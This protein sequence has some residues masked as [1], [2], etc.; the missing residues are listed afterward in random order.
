MDRIKKMIL[1][2][3]ARQP[4]TIDPRL[5]RFRLIGL[6]EYQRLQ[7]EGFFR[8]LDWHRAAKA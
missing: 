2:G 1:L 5:E 8:R 6:K 4:V 7:E 3:K